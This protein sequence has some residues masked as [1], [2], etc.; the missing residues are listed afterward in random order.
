M[1][2]HGVGTAVSSY[3]SARRGQ[4]R[5]PSSRS[6]SATRPVG[7]GLPRSLQGHVDRRGS[8]ALYDIAREARWSWLRLGPGREGAR[9]DLF[10]EAL[11]LLGMAA[12]A[13]VIA[14]QDVHWADDATLDFIRFVGCCLR[15]GPRLVRICLA[16]PAGLDQPLPTRLG[17]RLTA[18]GD[19]QLA[20]DG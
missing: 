14:I 4:E 1:D 9:L 11:D 3:W 17:G 6:L 13:A 8:R 10:S 12:G 20:Q 7:G 19:F 18:A 5:P 15:S 16:P 2:E